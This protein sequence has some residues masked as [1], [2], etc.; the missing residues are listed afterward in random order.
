MSIS[1]AT[2]NDTELTAMEAAIRD[3]RRERERIEESLHFAH[4]SRDTLNEA[5][6]YAV[7]WFAPAYI[8][9][10]SFCLVHPHSHDCSAVAYP[11]G[12]V[13]FCHAAPPTKPWIKVLADLHAKWHAISLQKMRETVADD[14]D[15]Y[16]WYHGRRI[17]RRQLRHATRPDGGEWTPLMGSRLRVWRR[18]ANASPI[19]RHDFF[20]MDIPGAR[21][22][23]W[24]QDGVRYGSP[25]VLMAWETAAVEGMGIKA[26]KKRAA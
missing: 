7:D 9:G 17:G 4:P 3:E 21:C 5:L 24:R 16:L 1:L 6:Y 26:K 14:I 22:L 12:R 20:R 2:L 8:H 18:Y 19:T 11:D 13:I 15:A 23:I 10:D 25:Y